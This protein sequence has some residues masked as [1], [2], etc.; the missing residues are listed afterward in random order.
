MK[1][2]RYLPRVSMLI[3]LGIEISRRCWDAGD[4]QAALLQAKGILNNTE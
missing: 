3:F 2:S 4:P 1:V